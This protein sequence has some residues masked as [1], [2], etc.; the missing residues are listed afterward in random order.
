MF[1]TSEISASDNLGKARISD[2]TDAEII[3]IAMREDQ[4]N[5]DKGRYFM[6]GRATLIR[7]IRACIAVA[8]ARQQEA[9]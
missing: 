1:T 2:M 3:E 4:S 8:L 6:C 9:V 5:L 7:I